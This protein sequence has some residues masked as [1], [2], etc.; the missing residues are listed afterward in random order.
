MSHYRIR[1]AFQ[2]ALR[3]F[4]VLSIYKIWNFLKVTFSFFLSRYTK[5]SFHWGSPVI[6]MVEPT[7]YCNLKCP[8]CP[9]G[10]GMM[11]RNKGMM[12]LEL[13]KKLIDT[14]KKTLFLT[15][16]WNQGEP[17]M[18]KTLMEQIK[19]AHDNKIATVVST[20]G[21]YI[22]NSNEAR[23]VIDSGLSELIISLDGA[24][25]ESYLKYRIGGDFDKV[26][27]AIRTLSAEKKKTG[28]LNPIIH[29]QFLL[30][31]HNQHEINRIDQMA[32]DL[33]V[34]KYSFK[35]VQVYT[36]KDAEEF[37]PEDSNMNRYDE[38][39]GERVLKADWHAGCKRIWYTTM[40]NWDGSMAPC[41]YDKDIDYKM[42]DAN[43]ENINDIWKNNE[44]NKFRK[45]VLTDRQSIEMCRN[46]AE[47][48][49]V[50]Q[51][52]KVRWIS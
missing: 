52:H 49:K 34:D 14:T 9:S 11:V 45:T 22:N 31:K 18:N 1:V 21:H 38:V 51:F 42:G 19:Y 35:T 39:D 4:H 17:F 23:S 27:N 40:V 29:L 5:I 7:N 10:N 12:D 46:C 30:F 41:C 33:G 24:S 2:T 8:L 50:K 44:F 37:L 20:N 48:L 32:A 47:G 36:D 3:N 26:L 6:L 13:F 43:N 25:K 16:F 15:M 28:A